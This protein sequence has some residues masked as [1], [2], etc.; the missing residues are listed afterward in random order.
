MMES[1]EEVPAVRDAKGVLLVPIDGPTGPT[2]L[3]I[4]RHHAAAAPDGDVLP[5]LLSA[6]LPGVLPSA[7]S[8]SSVD[9]AAVKAG[10]G[11][12][13]LLVVDD[14]GTLSAAGFK[15]IMDV[16]REVFG[17]DIAFRVRMQFIFNVRGEYSWAPFYESPLF[18]ARK[19]MNRVKIATLVGA[20]GPDPARAPDDVLAEFVSRVS[21]DPC[22]ADPCDPW[23][24]ARVAAQ[25][26]ARITADELRDAAGP[27]ALVG[28]TRG[29][30]A[31]AVGA[32]ATAISDDNADALVASFFRLSNGGGEKGIVVRFPYALRS[33]TSPLGF[34]TRL[35]VAVDGVPDGTPSGLARGTT[36]FWDGRT[37]P[38]QIF[39]EDTAGPDGVHVSA[40]VA[41]A[42]P[43][44]SP[45]S[46]VCRTETRPGVFRTLDVPL[47]WGSPAALAVWPTGLGDG[48][49]GKPTVLG[50]VSGCPGAGKDARLVLAP[51][52]FSVEQYGAV[53]AD[54]HDSAKL[55]DIRTAPV[56][57]GRLRI[58][59]PAPYGTGPP[60]RAH[61]AA[62]GVKNT[63]RF[64]LD[65]SGSS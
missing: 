43:S 54:L 2:S 65:R 36:L 50:R 45:I 8:A 13:L 16:L 51:E 41:V 56:P 17:V 25:N 38:D 31:T 29:G 7:F 21:A 47:F 14:A 24:T 57:G 59:Y 9:A 19:F 60:M 44:D 4:Y 1:D 55:S 33:G 5:C 34:V 18:R 53:F 40:P 63:K 3:G 15:R 32:V 58:N 64:K 12:R 20:P 11:R 48:T 49:D 6:E 28:A 35:E 52:A 42:Q 62:M 23:V 37:V 22:G 27:T 30:L 26:A 39:D 61:L 46:L 10:P